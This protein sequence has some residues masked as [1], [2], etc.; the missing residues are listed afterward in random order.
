MYNGFVP[1]W[2]SIQDPSK[3]PQGSDCEIDLGGVAMKVLSVLSFAAGLLLSAAGFLFFD[4]NMPI[5]KNP[6][7]L[8]G[9]TAIALIPMVVDS[10]REYLGRTRVLKPARWT[11]FLF[12]FTAAL[13]VIAFLESALW[14]YF[15]PFSLYDNVIYLTLA[16]FLLLII[17]FVITG[18]LAFTGR[19]LGVSAYVL[20]GV[21]VFFLLGFWGWNALQ[22]DFEYKSIE[23]EPIQL[24]VGGEEGYDIFRIPSLVIIPEGSSLADG[25]ILEKDLVLALA[26][27]RLNGSLD[28]GEIDLV[29]K[30]SLDG[31][32]NWSNLDVIRQWE[33]GSGK[34]GNPTPVFD[35]DVGIVYLFHI[36][37]DSRPYTTWVMESADGGQTFTEPYELGEGIVGPGHGIQLSTGEFAGRLLVPTHREGSSRAW[38]SD[39]HGKTWLMGAPVGHGNE[40]EIA[41]LSEGELLMAVRTNHSVAKPH[42]KLHQLFSRSRDGGG[43]WSAAEEVSSLKT[44]ICMVSLVSYD[45]VLYFSYPDDYYSRARMTVA[46]SFDGGEEFTEKLLIYPGPSGYSELGVLSNGDLLLLFEN[47]RVEY[48]QRLT[49]VRISWK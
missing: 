5:I 32:E 6:V 18:V 17:R 8:V 47:G 43:S 45:G 19:G 27:G 2:N 46:R 14:D 34:I 39:D 28:D 36:A 29:M 1:V 11:G 12:L 16:A 48:D 15:Q 7:L 49:L 38:Y 24:F 40:S 26:E 23:S 42:D 13:L 22:G 20:A 31:G 35:Q 44:P 37:G 41:E 10:V 30:R 3:K 33:G 21:S 4:Y 9:F 25:S